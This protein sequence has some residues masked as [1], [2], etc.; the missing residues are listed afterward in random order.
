MENQHEYENTLRLDLL[1]FQQALEALKVKE[2]EVRDAQIELETLQAVINHEAKDLAER[3]HIAGL[4]ET[5]VILDS[6]TAVI[7]WEAVDPKLAYHF[8]NFY[9]W[10]ALHGWDKPGQTASDDDRTVPS[11]QQ[12]AQ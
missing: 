1:K 10:G 12:S 6:H 8:I 5:A 2:R 3:L 9:E 7:A 11:L 4:L